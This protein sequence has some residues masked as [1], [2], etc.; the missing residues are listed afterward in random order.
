VPVTTRTRIKAPDFIDLLAGQEFYIA[1][2]LLGYSLEKGR[3]IFAAE[4]W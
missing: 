2:E 3:V 4:H 1:A